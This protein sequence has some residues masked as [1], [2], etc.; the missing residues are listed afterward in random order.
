M[1]RTAVEELLSAAREVVEAETRAVAGV[2]GQ[3]GGSF[4][5]A[6]EL[7]EAC[8]GK[9]V[10]A[11]AGTSGTVARRLAHL[12]SVTGTPAVYLHPADALHG[13]LGAVTANDI[14]V[15]ISKGGGSQELN[16]FAR[17]AAVRGA[18]VIAM[19]ANQSSA[20]AMAADL[21]IT[22]TTV[23]G[24]DPGEAIAMGSTLAMS[25]WGD[26]LAVILMRLRGYSWKEV[27]F[28]HPAGAVGQLDGE[29]AALPPLVLDPA[30]TKTT[31][32][33]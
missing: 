5:G 30:A 25:A 6:V 19:T 16:E 20:L 21:V 8:S 2:S 27:L 26:A 29:P 12:L 33:R 15:A 23:E 11:G 14:V 24:A 17:R 3:F 9:V 22:V 13:S 28:T 7:L 1:N 31:E 4:I 10:T 32:G 18:R